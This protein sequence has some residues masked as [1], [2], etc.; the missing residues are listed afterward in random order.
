MPETPNKPDTATKP[1]SLTNKAL[2]IFSI[3]SGL[4]AI[5]LLSEQLDLSS[6]LNK[7]RIIWSVAHN[8]EDHQSKLLQLEKDYADQKQIVHDLHAAYNQ[9]LQDY[10]DRLKHLEYLSDGMLI[11]KYPYDSLW[12][13]TMSGGWERVDAD[14]YNKHGVAPDLSH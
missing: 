2:L 12:I 13:R 14:L 5:I 1:R 3:V 11:G 4:S 9:T 6:G 7:L 10:G 8:L